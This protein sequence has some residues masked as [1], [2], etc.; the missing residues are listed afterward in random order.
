MALKVSTTKVY[1]LECDCGRELANP[2]DG[3][4]NWD[5]LNCQS[6]GTSVYCPDCAKN[7]RLPKALQAS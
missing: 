6:Y 4:L 1:S 3:S 7:Y 2:D 5:P